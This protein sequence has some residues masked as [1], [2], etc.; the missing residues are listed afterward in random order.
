M[1]ILRTKIAYLKWAIIWWKNKKSRTQALNSE[2]S[3]QWSQQI[4]SFLIFCKSDVAGHIS[5]TLNICDFVQLHFIHPVG[6][7]AFCSTMQEFYI[8]VS[9]SEVLMYLIFIAQKVFLSDLVKL[10]CYSSACSSSFQRFC[11]YFFLSATMGSACPVSISM[12]LKA[13][14]KVWDS[15]WQMKA[16]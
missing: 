10:F 13:H 7:L 9:A 4:Y 3:S 15:F 8:S 16:L 2:S 1:N 12:F 14:S 6:S 11:L 5:I